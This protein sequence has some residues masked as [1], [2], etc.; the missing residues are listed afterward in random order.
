MSDA[1]TYSW[2]AVE[3]GVWEYW[4]KVFGTVE[5][6]TA[7]NIRSL[8]KTLPDANSFIWKFKMGG[9]QITV[10][11]QTREKAVNGAWLM[12]AM[13]EA[14]TIDDDTALWIGG[15]IMENNPIVS[16]D[17]IGGLQRCDATVFPDRENDTIRLGG[18]DNAGQEILCVRVFVPMQVAFGNTE[19][20]V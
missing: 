5:G 15:I 11:R 17:G 20:T 1:F 9:G 6:L 14:W 4:N 3:R 12:D 16:T 13:L 7:Y 18:T 10:R 8:P 2:Q 19:R